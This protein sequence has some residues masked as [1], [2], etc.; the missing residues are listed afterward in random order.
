MS[1]FLLHV[2]SRPKNIITVIILC[3]KG[4]LR[5]GD[6]EGNGKGDEV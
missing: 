2:D 5:E 4:T 6:T 1:C 3:K